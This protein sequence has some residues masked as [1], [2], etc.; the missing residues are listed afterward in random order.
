MKI[1]RFLFKD[2]WRKL[3]ALAFAVGVYYQIN[4]SLTQKEARH[5]VPKEPEVEYVRNAVVQPLD[6]DGA[7]QRIAIF[8]NSNGKV[9]VS[10]S[11]RESDIAELK[12]EDVLFYVLIPKDQKN[13]DCE[14]PVQCYFRRPGI[15]V[16]SIKPEKMKVTIK[17][18]CN[19]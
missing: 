19:Q 16:R 18:I 4:N 5:G 14:L 8:D 12:D 15:R 1:L 11:G 10:L 17:S 6:Q 7:G 3:V 2:S 13:G 9:K